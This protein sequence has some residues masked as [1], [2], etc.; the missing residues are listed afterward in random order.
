MPISRAV[1]RHGI[2]I[3]AD[4][5]PSVMGEYWHRIKTERGERRDP[6]S[7]LELIP[8]PVGGEPTS[9][10]TTM[11]HQLVEYFRSLETALDEHKQK[12]TASGDPVYEKIYGQLTKDLA[13]LG[14]GKDQFETLAAQ[15]GARQY[16]GPAGKAQKE[17]YRVFRRLKNPHRW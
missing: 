16:A 7:N 8:E 15:C 17:T 2:V 10:D 13:A 11:Q 6:G 9:T 12:G 5:A 1:L 3:Q 14:V 4:D